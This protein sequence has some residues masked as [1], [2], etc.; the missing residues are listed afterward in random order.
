MR[1]GGRD[2]VMDM[3]GAVH[4]GTVVSSNRYSS[5]IGLAQPRHLRWAAGHHA[6]SKYQSQLLLKQIEEMVTLRTK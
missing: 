2:A 5:S 4:V 6:V 1:W 3:S